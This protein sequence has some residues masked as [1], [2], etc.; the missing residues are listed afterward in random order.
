MDEN[1]LE[2]ANK[3]RGS[4]LMGKPK[5]RKKCPWLRPHS[6]GIVNFGPFHIQHLAFV[7]APLELC[8]PHLRAI[9]PFPHSFTSLAGMYNVLGSFLRRGGRCDLRFV[10]DSKIRGHL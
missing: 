5:L 3:I 10:A 7:Y 6:F 2:K 8:R 4:W 1:R 9:F